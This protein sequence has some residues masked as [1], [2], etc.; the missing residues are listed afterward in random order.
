MARGIS[1][2]LRPAGRIVASGPC[3]PAS[4]HADRQQTS[5][6]AGVLSQLLIN[7][8]RHGIIKCTLYFVTTPPVAIIG[9]EIAD[10]AP[11]FIQAREHDHVETALF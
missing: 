8:S 9:D 2:T 11:A 7:D 6:G 5:A 4:M 1:A 3:W 10:C